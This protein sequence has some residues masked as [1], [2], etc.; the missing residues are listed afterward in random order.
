MQS[1]HDTGGVMYVPVDSDRIFLRRLMDR[2]EA[3]E[4]LSRIWTIGIIEETN[5]KLLRAK[6]IEA[7]HTHDPME[8]VRVINTARAR[9]AALPNSRTARLSETERSFWENAKRYLHTELALALGIEVND[10]ENYIISY[11]EKAE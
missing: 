10:V 5:A 9:A 4:F 1:L 3:E 6:Y 7:M 8:W 11:I 2:T